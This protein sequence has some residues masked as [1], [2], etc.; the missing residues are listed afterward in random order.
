MA[1]EI[2]KETL[3]VNDEPKVNN[4]V[5]QNYIQTIQDLKKNTVSRDEYEKLLKE[6]KNLL[7]TLVNGQ[8]VETKKDEAPVDLGKLRE[9]IFS[10]EASNLEYW[11]NAL[12]LREELIKRGERDP[13]LP[14]G[15]NIAPSYEDTQAA[16]RVADVVQQCIDYAEGDSLLFTQELQR[17][18]DDARVRR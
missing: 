8:E 1:E 12:K 17:R 16:E 6:N 14:Y 7:N 10:Q 18:T 15:E 9:K 4:D 11:Q 3:P 2:T 13:F 5:D